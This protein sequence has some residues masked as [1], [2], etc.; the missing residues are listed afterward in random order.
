MLEVGNC[1]LTM[2]EERAHFGTWAIAKSPLFI[3]TD[4]TKISSAS[5]A[6]L[7]NAVRSNPPFSASISLR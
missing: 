3:G 5:L 2:A 6:I 4:L 1:G 7:L